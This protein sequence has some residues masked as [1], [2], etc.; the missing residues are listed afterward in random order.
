MDVITDGA[1]SRH[2]GRVHGA[3]FQ[4]RQGGLHL[5]HVAGA[6]Q[7]DIDRR[8]AQGEAVTVAARRR[9]LAGRHPPRLQQVTPAGGGIGHHALSLEMGEDFGF[10]AAVGGII[11][12]VKEVELPGAFH[13][14]KQPALVP[15]QG[16]V[17]AKAFGLDGLGPFHKPRR[18]PPG[19]PAIWLLKIPL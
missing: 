10:G 17:P 7:A 19:A 3:A 18:R 4:D 6:A 5:L 11:A 15:G 14:R 12:D 8:V 16:Q 13:F 2:L 9:P 1:H